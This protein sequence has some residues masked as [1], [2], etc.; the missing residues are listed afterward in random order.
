MCIYIYIYI[1][2]YIHIYIYVYTYIYIYIYTHCEWYPAHSLDFVMFEQVRFDR[3][4]VP[5][6]LLCL[7]GKQALCAPLAPPPHS[8]GVCVCAGRDERAHAGQ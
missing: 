4:C 8:C 5:K 6:Q 3:P 7:S 1:Y 2:I